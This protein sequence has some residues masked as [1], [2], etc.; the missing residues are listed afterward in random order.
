MTNSLLRVHHMEVVM[1]R[2][3]RFPILATCVSL[4][5]LLTLL[6]AC[7]PSADEAVAESAEELQTMGEE[8]GAPVAAYS[9]ST[10]FIVT[11]PDLRR[12]AYP[13]CGGLF[14][15]RVNQAT[16]TCSDGSAQPECRVLEIDYTALGLDTATLD[17]LKMDVSMGRALLHGRIVKTGPIVGRTF[18]KLVVD[19]AWQARSNAPAP[20]PAPTLP[21]GTHARVRELPV[22]CPACPPYRHEVLNS[23]AAGRQV[24]RINYDATRFSASVIKELTTAL[25]ASDVGLLMAGTL[26]GATTSAS[27]AVSEAYTR[28]KGKPG[29]RLGDSC[30]S[31]GMPTCNAPLFCKWEPSANCGRSDASGVCSKKP[32]ACIALYKPV[33]G[34]DRKTYGNSCEANHAGVSVDYEGVCR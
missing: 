15:K 1:K 12:C 16:T 21:T 18:D 27:L 22:A 9:N 32:E 3:S 8:L 14:T 11:R 2:E 20:T 4:G 19:E 29:G 10:Y 34:C 13:Y 28:V 24:A 23:T 7:A 31:R 30:G 5:S 6:P 26:S 25:P 33:C 17:T